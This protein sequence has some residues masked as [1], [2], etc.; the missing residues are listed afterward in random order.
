MKRLALQLLAATP[1]LSALAPHADAAAITTHHPSL[2]P[3]RFGAGPAKRRF[4]YGV[5]ATTTART[6][7]PAPMSVAGSLDLGIIKSGA[8]SATLTGTDAF[9]TVANGGTLMAGA[10]SSDFIR[11]SGALG[12]SVIVIGT[13]NGTIDVN[14]NVLGSGSINLSWGVVLTAN[15][16]TPIRASDGLLTLGGSNGTLVING[17]FTGTEVGQALDGLN[18]GDGA[19]VSVNGTP[20]AAPAAPVPEPGAAMLF[21]LGMLAVSHGR[22]RV[23]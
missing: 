11:G 9:F 18:I 12:G 20:P 13:G 1:F 16:A 4:N 3:L 17:G 23:V 7:H 22:R 10:N 2:S 14:G 5:A 19:V 21:A 15:W 8:G 6:N